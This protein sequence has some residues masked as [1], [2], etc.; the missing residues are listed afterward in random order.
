M[1]PS[2]EITSIERVI[3]DV[4]YW[5]D[6]EEIA[7]AKTM[8]KLLHLCISSPLTNV[9]LSDIYD[10]CPCLESLRLQ[11]Y[12]YLIVGRNLGKR[13]EKRINDLTFRYY[14]IL[15][16][17]MCKWIVNMNMNIHILIIIGIM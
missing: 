14:I 5:G 11:Y 6:D 1:L 3:G 4:F 10:G 7:I 12:L 2:F 9:G 17:W 15:I 8:P 16:S 13:N